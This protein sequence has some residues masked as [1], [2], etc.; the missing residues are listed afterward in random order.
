MGII[1]GPG[2]GELLWAL[3]SRDIEV[4]GATRLS[5]KTSPPIPALPFRSLRS[6][7]PSLSLHAALPSSVCGSYSIPR[8][9]WEW[10]NI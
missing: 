9:T 3:A 4:T 2:M 7:A 5:V 10:H 1:S 6:W 8:H